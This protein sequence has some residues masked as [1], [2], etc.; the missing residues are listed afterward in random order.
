MNVDTRQRMLRDHNKRKAKCSLWKK[1]LPTL[2]KYADTHFGWP[3][4]WQLVSLSQEPVFKYF[5]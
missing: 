5:L 3:C 4:L 2:I 1:M